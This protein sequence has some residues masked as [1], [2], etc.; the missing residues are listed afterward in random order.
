MLKLST[1]KAKQ[2]FIVL[3]VVLRQSFI[4]D[5]IVIHCRQNQQNQHP[6][7]GHE[8][9]WTFNGVM[10]AILFWSFSVLLL[11]TLQYFLSCDKFKLYQSKGKNWYDV[12]WRQAIFN[13]DVYFSEMVGAS[14]I[15]RNVWKV[16][17]EK[18]NLWHWY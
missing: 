10:S 15:V 14:E 16:M 17:S 9:Y 5:Y 7:Q 12:K 11:F 4:S 1:S 6:F 3:T 2:C 18:H 13:F 8:K